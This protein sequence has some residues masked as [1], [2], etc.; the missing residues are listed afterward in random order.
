M[1]RV[2]HGKAAG[3]IGRLDHARQKT[4]LSDSRRLLIARRA[5]YRYLCAQM[6]SRGFSKICRR[7][8]HLRQH[9]PRHVEE[10]EQII[11]PLSRVNI[12]KERARSIGGIGHMGPAAGKAPDEE[13]VDRSECQFALL[14]ARE[15]IPYI[16]EYP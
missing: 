14:R 1:A 10:S 5:G 3:S 2:Q 7:I 4:C 6:S 11:V 15:G 13:A 8:L 16:V 9:R 12:V